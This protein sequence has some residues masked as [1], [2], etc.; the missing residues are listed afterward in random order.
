MTTPR[1][2]AR[3]RGVPSVSIFGPY[4]C[5]GP[6]CVAVATAVLLFAATGCAQPVA[7]GGG[8]ASAVTPLLNFQRI[9][10]RPGR[11]APQHRIVYGTAPQQVGELWLPAGKGPFP[12][13]LL[14]HGG[15]WMAELPGPELLAWQAEA[16][17]EQGWAVWS[18]SYRR[19]GHE[20]GGYP[21]TFLD[22]AHA[23]DRLRELA[24]QYPLDLDRVTVSGHSAGGHLALWLA[25]RKNIASNSP[26]YMPDPLRVQAVVSVAGIGDLAWSAP[27]IGAVCS[28]DIVP[29]LVDEARRG[30]DAY[31]DT[32]PALLGPLGV[33]VTMVSGV[34][35]PIV[36][37]AHARRY[38]QM[39]GGRGDAAVTLL[40]LQ[41]AGHFELIA[42]WTA[43]GAATVQAIEG[44]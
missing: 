9:L 20:G 16:L 29:K 12:V 24:R 7:S 40:N 14:V 21:G 15:C 39:A 5:I 17:R 37:P 31:A 2:R 1:D 30:K 36:P 34:Y 19:V 33:P 32:S 23:A 26:L 22:V 8:G 3:P 35:D 43:A 18:I 10:D 41:G 42:P 44:R 6:A 38:A 11:P 13:A 28:P 25:G 27:M 4:R